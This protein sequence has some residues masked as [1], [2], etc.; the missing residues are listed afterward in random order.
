[1]DT[2]QSGSGEQKGVGAI[3]RALATMPL[4]PGVYRM[5]DA[6]GEAPEQYP[7]ADD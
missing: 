1:M 5:L 6:H 2:E 7:G 4:S 3:E